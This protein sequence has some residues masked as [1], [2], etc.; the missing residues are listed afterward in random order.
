MRPYLYASLRSK[1]E[2]QNL[3][4]NKN[5]S[6]TVEAGSAISNGRSMVTRRM[7]KHSPKFWKK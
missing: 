4:K 5:G 2:L 3:V 1:T 6:L 7:E